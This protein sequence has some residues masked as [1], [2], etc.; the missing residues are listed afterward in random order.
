MRAGRTSPV[1]RPPA[2]ASAN[3]RTSLPPEGPIRAPNPSIVRSSRPSPDSARRF[4]A[5]A[6]SR[7]SV[8]APCRGTACDDRDPIFVHHT[9]V[10]RSLDLLDS[11]CRRP[12]RCLAGDVTR[13]SERGDIPR[14]LVGA[15]DRPSGVPPPRL[16]L[17]SCG[18]SQSRRASRVDRP[19]L[20]ADPIARPR[21]S[22]GS[23]PCSAPETADPYC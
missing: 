20:A 1:A 3:A 6:A 19:A 5:V 10:R 11:Y 4:Y 8:D 14:D 15:A 21:I 17:R 9:R 23:R 12:R 13:R 2:F 22:R 16:L 18:R 7:S